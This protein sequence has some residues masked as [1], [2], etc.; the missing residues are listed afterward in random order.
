[1][2]GRFVPPA[3]GIRPPAL[4]GTRERLFELFGASAREIQ[5]RP[6]Q[7]AFRFRSAAHWIEVFRRFYGPVERAFAALTAPQQAAL[8][9]EIHQLLASF[10]RS[11]DATLVAP[12]DYL[13][14]VVVR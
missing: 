3:P 11:G 7:A 1:V 14:I 5:V 2:I 4:W 13:E 8:E 9:A 10:N 12:S 6:R